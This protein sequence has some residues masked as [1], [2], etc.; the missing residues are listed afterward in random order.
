MR[1]ETK[2]F[3][4]TMVTVKPATTSTI[5]ISVSMKKTEFEK[6]CIVMNWMMQMTLSSIDSP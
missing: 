4:A 1:M 5:V 3:A 2:R 6:P